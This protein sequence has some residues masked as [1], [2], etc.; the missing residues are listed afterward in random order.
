MATHLVQIVER[1]SSARILLVGDFMLDRYIFGSTQRI[2]PEAPIPILHYAKEECRLGGAGFVLAAMTALEAKV[3][4]VG[5]AGDDSAAGDMERRLREVGV[6]QLHL[7]RVPGRPTVTKTRLLGSSEDRTPHQM[8]RLDVE[9]S[10][11]LS[12]EIEQRLI[13]LSIAAM[14]GVGLVCLEDY[15]KGVLS[16]KVCQA[17]I[18]AARQRGIPVLVDPA[19]VN[20]YGKYRGATLLKPNRL[21]AERATGLSARTPEQYPRVAEALLDA[22][23]LEAVVIT[24]NEKGAYLATRDDVRELLTGRPR[25]V[26]DGTGAGDTVLAMLAAARAS[27]A[28]YSDAVALANVA[29]GLEVERL[30]C[31]PVTKQE[32]MDDLYTIDRQSSGKQREL[33]ALLADLARDRAAGRK[34]VFTNGCFD[35]IHLGHVSYF[36]FARQ[37]GDRLVVAVNT[38]A[39]IQRLKGPNRPIVSEQD[40][41]AVLE[42]LESIDYLIRFD[43]DTPLKLIEQVRPDVLVKGADYKVEQVVGWDRVASW[44]GRVA[45]AP[46]VDGRS[47]TNVIQR[48]LQAYGK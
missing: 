12:D 36:R 15:N 19:R 3:R 10:A 32:V 27:G 4:A 26:A 11:P 13:D 28:G 25:E 38:D 45:L 35:L 23:D 1:L 20:D 48:I 14:K 31:V 17:I 41:L 16:A 29:G 24:L 22:L 8:I 30:G 46:L 47:T 43:D 6:E 34:I 37:Q 18:Q 40:R 5:L 33:G 44:G 39:S 7:L 2:S 42:E 9:D 21:E